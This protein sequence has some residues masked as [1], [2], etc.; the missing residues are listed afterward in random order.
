MA[1]RPANT[2]TKTLSRTDRWMDWFP[3]VALSH[4]AGHQHIYII[5]CIIHKTSRLAHATTRKRVYVTY[6]ESHGRWDC[7]RYILVHTLIGMFSIITTSTSR[8]KCYYSCTIRSTQSIVVTFFL[9]KITYSQ[10]Q[11]NEKKVGRIFFS[12]M[13]RRGVGRGGVEGGGVLWSQSGIFFFTRW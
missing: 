4:V 8:Y 5:A 6:L 1:Q 10:K 12:R 11:K 7:T 3:S 2:T 9:E 13:A